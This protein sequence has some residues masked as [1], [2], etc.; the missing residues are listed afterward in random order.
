MSGPDVK[1]LQ[2]ILSNYGLAVTINGTFGPKTQQA[3]KSLQRQLK[4]R[5]T[6]VV[7]RALLRRLASGP[8]LGS[9]S[10]RLGMRGSDV[11]QLQRVLRTRGRTVT[12]NGS[13]GPRTRRAVMAQQRRFGL[14]ATGV[15]NVTFLKRL[16]K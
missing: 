13:F 12:I 14:R 7:N 4:L 1:Q 5:A 10:L 6:G 2:A 9:R 3:V 15:A 16:A 8:L 11:K